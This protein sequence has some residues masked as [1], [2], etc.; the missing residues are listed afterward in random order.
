MHT[1]TH[2]LILVEWQ[3]LLSCPKMKEKAVSS[4]YAVI[5]IDLFSLLQLNFTRLVLKEAW[6][7]LKILS[8]CSAGTLEVN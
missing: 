3:P 6:M 2:T 5:A 4:K 8:S 7:L 1:H